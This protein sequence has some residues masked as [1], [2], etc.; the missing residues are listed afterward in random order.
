MKQEIT[1]GTPECVPQRVI[2]VAANVS[3]SDAGMTNYY[4]AEL[5][6]RQIAT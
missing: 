3:V 2:A 1:K 6:A 5:I 4:G